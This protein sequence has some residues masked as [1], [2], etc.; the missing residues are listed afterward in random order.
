MTVN[1]LQLEKGVY[2]KAIE[3]LHFCCYKTVVA[4]QKYS[5][6]KFVMLLNSNNNNE[7]GFTNY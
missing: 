6:T 4:I 2:S 5:Q 7:W 1:W 3:R